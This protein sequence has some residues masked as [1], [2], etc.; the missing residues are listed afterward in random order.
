MARAAARGDRS[1]ALPIVDDIIA[2]AHTMANAVQ[3]LTDL[4]FASPVR[5][6]VHALFAGNAAAV[7]A[8]AGAGR[9]VS[10]NTLPHSSNAIDVTGAL[11]EAVRVELEGL[12][13]GCEDPA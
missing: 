8:A 4:G 12:H 10:C 13:A 1:A 5:V 7:L 9:V 11:A 2:S 6:G 3:R